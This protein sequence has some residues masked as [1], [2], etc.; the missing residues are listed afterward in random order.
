M[1]TCYD[2]VK[3]ILRTEKST[4][5]EPDRQYVFHV[6]TKATKV[7]IKN[8]VEEIYKV[9]VSTVNTANVLGKPKRTRRELGYESNWKKAIVTLKDGH[10]IEVT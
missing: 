7:D 9:K 3:T 1:I 6:A 10:K 8:A 2:T 4:R 5:L